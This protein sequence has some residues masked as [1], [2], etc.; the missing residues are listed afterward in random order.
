MRNIPTKF[1]WLLGLLILAGLI[2]AGS[3]YY[4]RSTNKASLPNFAPPSKEDAKDR[5]I[6][7]AQKLSNEY[8]KLIKRAFIQQ[9]I[10]GTLKAK[11]ENSWT[12][13]AEGQTLT[14]V[15]QNTNKI[16]LSKLPKIAS[17]SSSSVIYPVE[18]KPEDLKVGDTVSVNQ[19]IEWDSGQV[20]ITGITV[21]SSN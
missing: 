12:I 5:G 4:P 17:G 1:R 19:L 13:E 16:F 14:L 18:I 20:M 21:L 15:N 3:Y 11:E 8:P 10:E 9:Q 7:T 2:I 6:S